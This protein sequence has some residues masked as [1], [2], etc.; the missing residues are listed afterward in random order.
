MATEIA[1]KSLNSPFLVAKPTPWRR[2]VG[3][4]RKGCLP[5]SQDGPLHTGLNRDASQKNRHQVVG[6]LHERPVK[7]KSGPIIAKLEISTLTWKQ[8]LKMMT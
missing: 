7:G 1:A 3:A 2:A 5:A 4:M 6:L 8:F